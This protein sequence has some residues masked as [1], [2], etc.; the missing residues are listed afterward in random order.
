MVLRQPT[1]EQ[2]AAACEQAGQ[3]LPYHASLL[4]A[5]A[6]SPVVALARGYKSV[7]VRSTSKLVSQERLPSRRQVKDSSYWDSEGE[8]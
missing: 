4:V 6:I 2:F 8:R 3:L 7:T 5:S 1:L